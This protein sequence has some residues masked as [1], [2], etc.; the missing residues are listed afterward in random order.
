MK[1]IGQS[2]LIAA[3]GVNKSIIH[4]SSDAHI[5]SFVL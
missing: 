1:S 4:T 3:V 5:A 2:A